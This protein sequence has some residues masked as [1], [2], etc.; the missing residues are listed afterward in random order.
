MPTGAAPRRVSLLIF[1]GGRGSRLGGLRKADLVI[2]GRTVLERLLES[3]SPL[4]DERLALVQDDTWPTIQ[5]LRFVVDPSPY[6]GP[7]AALAHGL[8]TATGDV[9]LL[10]ASDMPFVSRK[11]FAF[12]L[13]LQAS[14]G[15]RAVVPFVDGFVESMHAVVE[16]QALI[17]A[18]DRC[19]AK[20]EQRLFKVL[21]S[22]DPRLV[23]AAELRNVDPELRS[24]F[25]IN[26]PEDLQEAERIAT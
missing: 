10:V 2:G 6:A 11:A 24:L 25:N 16:R 7:L 1:A 8:R 26:T 14:T 19:Q 15:A 9:C 4:A 18:I 17:E 5:G 22:L 23:E 20:G 21:E 12:L 3:L 13:Q